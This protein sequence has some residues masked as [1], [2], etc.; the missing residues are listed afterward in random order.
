MAT[1][2]PF[3]T[4]LKNLTSSS[5]NQKDGDKYVNEICMNN[6][7][8]KN[9]PSITSRND[10]Q[11]LKSQIKVTEKDGRGFK[12]EPA[13]VKKKIKS[14]DRIRLVLEDIIFNKGLK[15]VLDQLKKTELLDIYLV[16]LPEDE[17]EEKARSYNR[18]CLGKKLKKIIQSAPKE[19]FEKAEDL[20]KATFGSVLTE[21]DSD[22]SGE[23]YAVEILAEINSIGLDLFL[24]DVPTAT[25]KFHCE[26]NEYH[27]A[28]TTK[29]MIEAILT[30]Q[31]IAKSSAVAKKKVLYSKTKL[32]LSDKLRYQDI[33]QHY[34]V[35][36]LQDFCSE[37]GM[38]TS[39]T[40]KELIH[41]VMNFF[42]GHIEVP[43]HKRIAKKEAKE[44]K[45]AEEA[46]KGNIKSTKK[47]S[48]KTKKS[49]KKVDEVVEPV[50]DVEPVEYEGEQSDSEGEEEQDQEQNTQTLEE[51]DSDV[52]LESAEV[53]REEPQKN[54]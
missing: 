51:D 31:D 18:I 29:E 2:L 23:E 40:K 6:F 21:I 50:E 44:A 12:T 5:N 36:E 24:R 30:G 43:Y 9:N 49:T 37:N 27:N 39:G 28:T 14:K 41:R 22:L 13:E 53:V 26:K 34:Y 1:F 32:P 8:E 7:I 20:E 48:I 4:V 47:Q 54:L 25:L 16:W 42:Q 33:F 3:Q 15:V 45:E 46:A 52:E 11:T 10:Y 17:E 35:N 38:K 19:F